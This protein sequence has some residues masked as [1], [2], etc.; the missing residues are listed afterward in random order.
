MI[1]RL[2]G[3]APATLRGRL[4]L[5]FAGILTFALL[6]VVLA[7]PNLLDG[8]FRQQEQKNL[9][10]RARIVAAN[11]QVRLSSALNL[12]STTPD[13]IVLATIP[14]S[15]SP[16]VVTTLG[17]P[18]DTASLL[19][20]VTSIVAQ[21]DLDL[22]IA[23][24]EG[25]A[26]QV[27]YHVTVAYQPDAPEVGA[28]RDSISVP[29]QF[30]MPD[31]WWTQYTATAP[32]RP[33]T[34]VL[35]NPY[36]FRAQTLRDVAGVLLAAALVAL[37][38]A[39]LASIAI[40]QRLTTPIRRLT[41]ASRALGEGDLTARVPETA[42][43]GS[44]EIGELATTFNRMADRLEESI[45]V[46]RRDRDRSRD[47][48]AEVSH[49]LRTPIAAL[50]TFNE[51]LQEGASDDPATRGEFLGSSRQQIDRLD[52]LAANLLELSKLD[53]GLVALDLRPDDL[54]AAVEA[55]GQQAEPA[56]RRKGVELS[57]ELPA[58]PLRQRHDP[59]RIGQ[60]MS[61]LIGNGVKFTPRGGRVTVSLASVPDGAELR[62][63]DTGIGIP[64]AELPHVFER[65]YRG[66]Q[67]AEARGSGSG[68]GLSIVRSIVEMHGGRVTI[69][70]A[71]GKGTEVL[72]FLPREM[73][74]SS[75]S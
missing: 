63:R 57:I 7:L 47:F 19:Y 14:R 11:I 41:R 52:W 71:P 13:A 18:N 44:P 50:R 5:A 75:P 23:T 51:L 1:E 59:Q 74:L 72:V 55:A 67:A 16:E 66:V 39:V 56:A 33:F 3:L 24:G 8:Y 49:E 6:L 45:E 37:L 36:T 9:L 43:G 42:G 10:T 2:R 68:L 35:S 54:R 34:L 4:I 25:T 22:S 28:E 46:I 32:D 65:F 69:E 31:R 62:V 30:T 20:Q 15:I 61:N 26:G 58:E 73:T 12:N 64:P 60:V 29:Y 48:L 27:V 70:S 21:S 53:S 17:N 38:V 40:A